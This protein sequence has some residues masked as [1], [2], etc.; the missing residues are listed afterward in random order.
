MNG[1]YL[2]ASVKSSSKGNDRRAGGPGIVFLIFLTGIGLAML[3]FFWFFIK[4]LLTVQEHDAVIEKRAWKV[5]VFTGMTQMVTRTGSY[6]PEGAELISTSQRSS[7]RYDYISKRWTSHSE[8]RYKYRR[9]EVVPLQTLVFE[10]AGD[11]PANPPP[12]ELQE[13]ERITG[14]KW[15]YAV[16]VNEEGEVWKSRVTEAEFDIMRP[17]TK[18]VVLRNVFGQFS[19]YRLGQALQ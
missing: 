1:F 14:S 18:V 6:L 3:L 2:P 12:F 8:T 17:D 13:G 19:G 7:R 15:E 16:R 11:R 10:E 9:M 5:T 4:M